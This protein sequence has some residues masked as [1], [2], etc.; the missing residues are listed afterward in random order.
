MS[1]IKGEMFIEKYVYGKLVY[2]GGYAESP[3]IFKKL[4]TAIDPDV[5]KEVLVI[6]EYYHPLKDGEWKYYNEDGDLIDTEI[7]RHGILGDG[8]IR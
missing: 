6:K 3:D 4:D 1:S 5:L 7:W 2:K 8:F